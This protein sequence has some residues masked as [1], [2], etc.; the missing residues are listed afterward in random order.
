[1]TTFRLRFFSRWTLLPAFLYAAHSLGVGGGWIVR[2]RSE[3][4]ESSL[5]PFGFTV[6]KGLESSRRVFK[7]REKN[8]A[9]INRFQATSGSAHLQQ[10]MANQSFVEVIEPNYIYSASSGARRP[11]EETPSGPIRNPLDFVE[12]FPNDPYFQSLWGLR[13]RGQSVD[14]IRGVAGADIKATGAWNFERGSHQVLVAV[15]DSGIDLLHEDLVGN[16]WSSGSG[17]DLIHGFNALHPT[18]APQDD[19]GHGTHV[20]GTIGAV[21]D[22]GRGVTGVNWKVSLM[23]VKVLDSQGDGDLAGI[24]EGLDWAVAHGAQVINASWGGGG[25]SQILQDSIRAAGNQGVLFVAAAGNETRNNDVYASYP[26]NYALSNILSVAA[27][28]NQDKLATFSN[29]GV[30]KVHIA[31]PGVS[32]YSTLPNNH[33]GP[34][35]GTSMATPFVS[36]A[37][38]LVL[39]KY[40]NLDAEAVKKKLIDSA[41]RVTGL[42]PKVGNNGARLNILKALE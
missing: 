5:S 11:T 18:Q 39:S 2:V 16:L 29:Y 32:I 6:E 40:P 36:G 35:S 30:K 24:V 26:A 38:A 12:V 41:D 13:N 37:A 33:Y 22:N 42:K 17:G 1:M 27:T 9:S 23:A 3:G 8:R 7:I 28:D 34:A 25:S 14:L 19:N 31:A 21:G 4:D 15:L 20:A 10:A